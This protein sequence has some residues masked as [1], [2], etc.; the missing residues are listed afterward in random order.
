MKKEN[1]SRAGSPVFLNKNS[2]KNFCRSALAL[3]LAAGALGARAEAAPVP[4]AIIDSGVDHR[5]SLLAAKMW[6]N[7]REVVGNGKDDDRNGKV[8]DQFGWNFA[9]KNNQIIDYK[10]L[11]SFSKDPY[12]YFEIQL[13]GF[14][15]TATQEDRD[16][17]AQRRA[18]PAFLAEMQKFGNFVH[19]T[20]VAGIAAAGSSADAIRL[21]G[22][23]IL[24]TEVKRPFE[25]LEKEAA[26]LGLQPVAEGEPI[27]RVQDLLIRQLLAQLAKANGKNLEAVGLYS[28][29]SGARVANCSFGSSVPALSAALGPILSKVI[30]REATEAE[31]RG[32][33][34]FTIEQMLAE[35]RRFAVDANQTFFVVAAGNDGSDNDQWP[36]YPANLERRNVISVAATQG[37]RRLAPFS[38]YGK[39]K[40]HLAAPGV[41]IESAIPGEEMLRVSGTSQ[42]APF[43]TG[44]VARML[45]ENPTLGFEQVRQIL[46]GTVDFKDFLAGKVISGGIVNAERAIFAAR[47]LVAN[48][49]VESVMRLARSEVADQI[50]T[51]EQRWLLDPR[52]EGE[53]G[54]FLPL[55]QLLQ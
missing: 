1:R 19:G 6:N 18:D 27:G 16:W 7:P 51:S 10:Y 43:V 33:A 48:R 29:S 30:G 20:H 34:S 54:L 31:V 45:A 38:N 47:L 11:G 53:S 5:H 3:V 8:D 40:V 15:G 41:G 36:V 55:P 24:P 37:L 49:S 21:I 26:R 4:V 25:S 2:F 46:M 23:K 50:E 35:G 17:V 42:A 14:N 32:Y 44:V 13:R 9:E 28:F 22:M 52:N 39:T 12:R